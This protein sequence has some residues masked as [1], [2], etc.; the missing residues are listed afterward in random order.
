MQ[1]KSRRSGVIGSAEGG[2][3]L[4]YSTTTNTTSTAPAPAP[5]PGPAAP[6]AAAT[7]QAPRS[8]NITVS[9]RQGSGVQSAS[10]PPQQHYGG[11]HHQ[12]YHTQH[13]GKP[14]ITVV[15]SPPPTQ[16]SP[17][18]YQSPS[19][20]PQQ[21]A[22]FTQVMGIGQRSASAPPAQQQQQP[23]PLKQ[24]QPQPLQQPQPTP[25]QLLLLF[26]AT[27]VGK[28]VEVES[29]DGTAYIGVF[30]TACLDSDDG[31]GV[32]LKMATPK[33]TKQAGRPLPIP[34][35][36]IIQPKDFVQLHMR[37]WDWGSNST[38]QFETDAEIGERSAERKP[39]LAGQEREL[40]PWISEDG[41]GGEL[42]PS[43]LT[44]EATFSSGTWNQFE[45]NEK[46]FGI[47]TTYREEHYTTPLDRS[48]NFYRSHLPIAE[49]LARE[50][51]LAP[52][53][54][55]H[56]AEERG[57]AQYGDMTEEDR[58][59]A[60]IQQPLPDCSLQLAQS[61]PLV[62]PV[63]QKQP[64]D[65]YVPPHRRHQP[66]SQ[67]QSQPQQAQPA[68][69][70]K[71]ARQHM[72]QLEIQT[73]PPAPQ[74]QPLPQAL[75]RPKTPSSGAGT[76][77]SL[78][79]ATPESPRAPRSPRSPRTSNP[80]S[81]RSPRPSTPESP[82]GGGSSPL[83]AALGLQCQRSPVLQCMPSP[84]LRPSAAGAAGAVSVAAVA[85]AVPEDADKRSPMSP[86]FMERLR[87]RQGVVEEKFKS[88]APVPSREDIVAETPSGETTPRGSAPLRS[89]LV[90]PFVEN[91]KAIQALHLEP[92]A[93]A[94]PEDL[95]QDF[96]RFSAEKNKLRDLEE[97]ER[98][99]ASLKGFK[100]QLPQLLKRK[101]I[102]G[103]DSLKGHGEPLL[104]TP[105]GSAGVSPVKLNPFASS[106]TPKARTAPAAPTVGS[107][108]SVLAMY[109]AGAEARRRTSAAADAA[110]AAATWPPGRD[111]PLLNAVFGDDASARAQAGGEQSPMPSAAA[112]PYV[113][114]APVVA[115]YIYPPQLYAMQA[116][117]AAGGPLYPGAGAR[118]V[119]QNAPVF[120]PQ[121]GLPGYGAEPFN[122]VMPLP[123]FT[124]P[125]MYP[126]P[127]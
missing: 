23:Q 60:V 107:G 27:L 65:V 11:G 123:A 34:D 9:L 102:L 15:K 50:T 126:F 20:P 124:P 7:T 127:Q 85:T 62:P 93:P 79:P 113:L 76:A 121:Y 104:P 98:V 101:N 73:P 92:I 57:Q 47:T 40:T 41:N 33:T 78:R 74:V 37:C 82:R 28:T 63:P 72:K 32:I 14:L 21:K 100:D 35:T 90:S 89:P 91:P 103:D 111:L 16:P 122:G 110:A 125:L 64:E 84:P 10:P 4:R 70:V 71:G 2:G 52:T 112:A 36:V 25:H 44:M 94:L 116:A 42:I 5:A 31:F 24:S 18:I 75:A 118:S 61:P 105:T 8:P 53:A 38:P 6:S 119:V 19:P 87:V 120:I 77:A 43:N 26:S 86:L 3:Y 83:M 80:N 59:G 56:L 58:Y 117:A 30:H 46:L 106:F 99:F 39:S 12:Q 95:I 54:N 13:S 96:L 45:V 114:P 97:R 109:Y 17:P 108:G 81:P 1:F 55:P 66:Q 67:P 48:S 115:P 22:V 51:E 69:K 29:R 88:K 68:K 49:K